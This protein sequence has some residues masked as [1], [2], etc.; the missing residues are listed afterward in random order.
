LPQQQEITEA[1]TMFL[2]S[3]IALPT[4]S[5]L[6]LT[7]YTPQKPNK[8]TPGRISPQKYSAQAK[9]PREGPN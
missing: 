3:F 8:K 2:S 1:K 6:N 7:I 4:S 9:R 5:R